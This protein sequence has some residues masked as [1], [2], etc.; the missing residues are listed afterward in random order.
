MN[1]NINLADLQSG[2]SNAVGSSVNE[3]VHQSN[4]G[5]ANQYN[6]GLSSGRGLLNQQSNTNQ[7]L[8]YGD[9]ATSDA[10]KSRYMKDYQRTENKIKL[11]NVRNAQEDHIRNLQ[12]ASN[13]AG[14]EVEQNKQKSILKWKIDQ[15]NKASRGQA[16]GT[17]LGIVG[18]V[19]GG[20]TGGAA[21]AGA[22]FAAG[23]GIGNA[24]GSAN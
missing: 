24:Y 14:Q 23:S 13:A 3:Q 20:V 7:G 19:A 18:G 5:L 16:L 15:A 2:S 12:M 22:G 17:V 6:S 8:A 11:D 9:Q 1:D 4:A 10:I 21:G